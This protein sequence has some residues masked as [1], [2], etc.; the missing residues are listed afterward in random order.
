MDLCG[1]GEHDHGRVGAAARRPSPGCIRSR[2]RRNANSTTGLFG[3]NEP[4]RG[5]IVGHF[6]NIDDGLLVTSGKYGSPTETEMQETVE[7]LT[8]ADANDNLGYDH[9]II[10]AH[11]GLNPLGAEAQ[12]IAT[13]KR[14]NIYGRNRL[15]NFHLM[16]DSG[17]LDEVFGQLSRSPAVGRIGGAWSDWFFEAGVGKQTGSYAWRNMKQDALMAFSRGSEYDGGFKGL[18]PLLSGLDK[19]PRRP[20]LH[21]VGHS[22]GANMLGYLLSSL[23]RF[24]LSKIELGTIHLMAPACT[25][26]FFQGALCALSNRQGRGETAG[27]DLPIQSH[28][29]AGAG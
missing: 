13:W 5:D 11:G 4:T 28:G 20:K 25:V 17:F 3:Y 27:P 19:A 16:W 12:R 6:V 8:K 21:L 26:A 9:L 2:P 22:A 29:P 1:L 23:G 15:Y 7:R 14:N 18:L 24:K 10:Y